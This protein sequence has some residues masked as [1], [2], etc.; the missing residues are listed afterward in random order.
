MSDE[1]EGKWNGSLQCVYQ[2]P[3]LSKGL[4]DKFTGEGEHRPK[5]SDGCGGDLPKGNNEEGRPVPNPAPSFETNEDGRVTTCGSPTGPDPNDEDLD[6]HEA[7][8]RDRVDLEGKLKVMEPSS[9]DSEDD[10][11]ELAARL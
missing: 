1:L 10:R 5:L 6:I 4:S 9:E 3:S 11:E 2:S 7:A 8:L